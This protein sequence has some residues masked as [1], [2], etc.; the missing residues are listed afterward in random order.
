MEDNKKDPEK[1]DFN[2]LKDHVKGYIENRLKLLQLTVIEYIA[3][4][5]PVFVLVALMALV[6]LVFWI[7]VNISA[8]IAIGR[9]IDSMAFGFLIISGFNLL[10][11]GFFVLTFKGLIQKPVSN[12][13]VKILTQSLESDDN[14]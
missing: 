13:I 8:A 4:V 10:L 3:K 5:S 9:A 6:L 14:K 7:F 11:C 1:I 2:D 12:W